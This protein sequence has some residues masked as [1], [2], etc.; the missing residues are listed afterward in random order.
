MLPGLQLEQRRGSRMLLPDDMAAGW[1]CFDGP[2]EKRRLYPIPDRW[3]DLADE[4]LWEMCR[5][6]QA[7]R[8][9]RSA[10]V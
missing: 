2:A 9:L 6:A 7:V 3:E 4:D 1:L 10:S 8:P 5:E